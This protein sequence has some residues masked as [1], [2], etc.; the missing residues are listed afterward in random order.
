[1]NSN[2]AN[3]DRGNFT[4]LP[5]L[6][7]PKKKQPFSLATNKAILG[8]IG[9]LV[10]AIGIITALIILRKPITTKVP[11]HVFGKID[12]CGVEIGGTIVEEPQGLGPDPS[13][14]SSTFKVTYSIKNK[15]GQDR[16]VRITNAWYACPFNDQPTCP[17]GPDHPANADWKDIQRD[18]RY[19]EI[20]LGPNEEKTFTVTAT[21][22]QGTCGM[23]QIDINLGAVFKDGA[24]DDTCNNNDSRPGIGGLYLN[25]NACGVTPPTNTPTVSIPPTD[26]P[27]LSETPSSTPIPSSTASPTPS[28][29]PTPSFTST[30]TPSNT[31]S[32]PPPG[33]TNTPTPTP[34]ATPPPGSTATN[35]PP[36]S[37]TPIPVG[38]ATKGCDNAANPCRSG[39]ICLQ[40]LDGSNYCMMPE[41]QNACKANPSQTSCCTAPTEILLAKNT[42]VPGASATTA[43][44]VSAIPSA[45]GSTFS[46]IFGV[47]SAVIILLGLIL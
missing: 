7:E 11:A 13:K 14:N 43:P 24:W 30:P 17:N 37:A 36:P 33:S 28:H 16:G 1:M 39:Q 5:P 20:M 46:K 8:L 22:P 41:F 47:V 32:P 19:D 18:P 42:S 35:T 38:C 21:Q 23:F 29:T 3:G 9:I 25:S 26:T 6:E 27:V 2:M 15:R 44:A 4:P 12:A 40:A 45:G 31:P 10:L 34:S